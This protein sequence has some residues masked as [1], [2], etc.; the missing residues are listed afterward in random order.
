M[1]HLSRHGYRLARVASKQVRV[2]ALI[3]SLVIGSLL[4]AAALPPH[5]TPA[6][7]ALADPTVVI[8][9]Q[10][11]LGYAG[12]KDTYI[13]RWFPDTSYGWVNTMS[14]RP[15][16][17]VSSLVYFD[18]TS[19]PA[20]ANVISAQ[21]NLYCTGTGGQPMDVRTFRV[22]RSWADA[23]ATWNMATSSDAWGLPGAES[24]ATDR[25]AGAESSQTV[26]AA[27]RWYSWSVSEMVQHWINFPGENKGVVLKGYGDHFVQ[28][29]FASSEYWNKDLRPQLQVTYIIGEL[30]TATPTI[31]R[32][33]TN[34]A[35]PTLTPWLTST[36]TRTVTPTGTPGTPTRTPTPSATPGDVYIRLAPNSRSVLLGDI[37]MMDIMIDASTPVDSAAVYLNYDPTKLWVVDEFGNPT[38]QIIAGTALSTVFQNTADNGTGEIT[39]IAGAPLPPAPA[40]SGTFL[41]GTIRFKALAESLAGTGVNFSLTPPRKTTTLYEGT[42]NL[43]GATDGI[44]YISSATRTPTVTG[45]LPTATA[46]GTAT[47]TA[48]VTATPPASATATRTWTPVGPTPGNV[49]VYISPSPKNVSVNDIFTLNIMVNALTQPVDSASVYL[50][51]DPSYLR[52]VDAS[53][54]PMGSIIPSADF[55][56]VFENTVDNAL[57]TINYQAGIPTGLPACNGVCTIATMRFKALNQTAGTSVVFHTTTPRRTR[58]IMAGIVQNATTVPGTVVIQI[59]AP[60]G[61]ATQTPVHTATPTATQTATPTATLTPSHTPTGTITPGTV[62]LLLEPGL[63]IATVGE[64]FDLDVRVNAGA[65]PVD[66]VQFHINFNAAC[67][68]VVSVLPDLSAL[69]DVVSAPAWDNTLGQV[70]YAG[71]VLVGPPASGSFRVATIRFLATAP[72]GGTVISFVYYPP[73]RNTSVTYLGSSVL[74]GSTNSIVLVMPGGGAATATP[75]RTNTPTPT[76]SPTATA[77]PTVTPTLPSGPWGTV[78]GRV[79]LEGRINHSGVLVTIGPSSAVTAADGTFTVTGVPVGSYTVRAAKQSYLYAEKAGVVV[80][81]GLTTPLPDVGLYGGDCN[82]DGM[83]DLYDMVVVGMAYEATPASPHWDPTADINGDNVVDLLDLVIIG[84]NFEK[85]APTAWTMF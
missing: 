45:T 71:G 27:S 21:L 20:G 16:N 12:T 56:A 39:L 72:V 31:T 30:P 41:V 43:K 78:T 44:V 22:L 64:I 11:N 74:A 25:V 73:L 58:L 23:E 49:T 48:T 60:T 15:D 42:A 79:I 6:V 69:P 1:D 3:L 29:A 82:G 14:V 40:P 76:P 38:G 50:D 9:Q 67:L 5:A 83:V 51:F 13:N 4:G 54:N 75:T 57:G 36:P 46:T 63:K 33:P 59:A 84:N 80:V 66:N 65:Q 55:G 7:S 32:T 28:F 10:G 17:Y 62:T 35:T 2:L 8:F 24:T 37:F 19:I 18:L 61:T 77:T 53:G 70:S 81:N 34:S 85:V 68:Q 52:V 47:S 26:L